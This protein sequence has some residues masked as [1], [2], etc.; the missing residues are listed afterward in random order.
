[1]NVASHENLNFLNENKSKQGELSVTP[2]HRCSSHR[3]STLCTV[4]LAEVQASREI[5]KQAIKVIEQV[6]SPN[7][8]CISQGEVVLCVASY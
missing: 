5:D 4:E 7:P 1:M 8:Q 6:I 2:T 3:A